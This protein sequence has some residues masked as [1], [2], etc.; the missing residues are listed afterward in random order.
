MLCGGFTVREGRKEKVGINMA[1]VGYQWC[2][3]SIST[4][5]VH[6][7]NSAKEGDVYMYCKAPF[8]YKQHGGGTYMGTIL[9]LLVPFLGVNNFNFCKTKTENYHLK[10]LRP[11]CKGAWCQNLW[12]SIPHM[13]SFSHPASNIFSPKIPR[14]SP[15]EC[16]E[17]VLSAGGGARQSSRLGIPRN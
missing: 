16:G 3:S 6:I 7:F 10:H 2:I 1:N 8:L 17:E 12:R 4:A 14:D 15:S 9:H 13:R 11:T 5:V